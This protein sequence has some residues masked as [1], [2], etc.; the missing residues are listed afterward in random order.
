M[1][2]LNKSE[3]SAI[4]GGTVLNCAVTYERQTT[5]TGTSA[6]STCRKVTTCSGKYGES[7]TRV[8]ADLASC[9]V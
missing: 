9:G 3:V 6:V 7:V 5:G 1:K 8:P 4:V 2:K